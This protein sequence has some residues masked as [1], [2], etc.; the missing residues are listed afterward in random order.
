ML[1]VDLR[2]ISFRL[3]V[4]GRRRGGGGWGGGQARALK[5]PIEKK[6]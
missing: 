1:L 5:S 2:E 3:R 4:E 6:L